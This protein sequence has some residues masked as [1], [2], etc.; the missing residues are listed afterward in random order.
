MSRLQILTTQFEGLKMKEEE[1]VHDFHMSILDYANTFDS[2]GEK[3]PDEK[4]VRKL[5]R[6]LPPRFDMKVTAIEEFRDIASMKLDELVGSLQTFELSIKDRNEKKSK[7]ISFVS[8][9]KE[10][11]ESDK[12]ADESISDAL[13]LL[14]RQFNK[15]LKRQN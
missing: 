14:G 10:E 2:L 1:T 4:L 7:S 5:L 9:T 15:I 13:V 6:S 11:L 3:L 8:N 12:E